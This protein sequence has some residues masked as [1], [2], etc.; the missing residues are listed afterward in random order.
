M[1]GNAAPDWHDDVAATLACLARQGADKRPAVI[2]GTTTLTFAELY[3]AARHA[4]ARTAAVNG[5]APLQSHS[6]A[7]FVVR[8]AAAWLAGFAPLPL[9]PVAYGVA[10]R[11]AAGAADR[12]AG[13][14]PWKVVATAASGTYRALVTHGEPPSRPRKALALGMRPSG[15]ALIASPLHLNGPLE[16]TLR[17]LLLGGTVI[18]ARR[19]TPATWVALALAHK[20]TWAFLVPTQIRRLLAAI[21]TAVL[22][23]A[24]AGLEVLMHSSQPCPPALR[25][26]LGCLLGNERIAE[27]YGAAEYDGTFRYSSDPIPGAAPIPGAELRVVDSTR[28]PVPAG[29]YGLIEGRSTAGLISHPAGLPC[30]DTDAWATVGDHGRESRHGRLT[31]TSVAVPGRAI[32]GGINVALGH[33]SSVL[34]AHPGISRCRVEAVPDPDYGQVVAVQATAIDPRLTLSQLSAYC[35]ARLPAAARPRHLRL[36]YAHPRSADV[37]A[38]V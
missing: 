6:D 26:R 30:P 4:A 3:T 17:H 7:G 23:K 31:V 27:Y 29:T 37:P 24:T 5:I 33:V 20:P 1:T 9:P 8:A 38:R 22:E 25:P 2:D 19:F 12:P 11:L 36:T 10:S 21:P 35:A 28:H 14:Q 18:L 16:F 34:L 15:I 13:C 32:V